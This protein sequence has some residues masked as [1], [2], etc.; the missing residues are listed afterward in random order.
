MITA[1]VLSEYAWYSA[2]ESEDATDITTFITS[3]YGYQKVQNTIM[4][5]LAELCPDT[6]LLKIKV[7]LCWVNK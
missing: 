3:E 1:R 6:D 5:R 4:A 2:P 7:F